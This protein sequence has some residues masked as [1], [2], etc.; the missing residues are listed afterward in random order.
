M[1]MGDDAMGFWGGFLLL[2]MFAF[3]ITFVVF[4]LS[5][6]HGIFLEL[7]YLVFCFLVEAFK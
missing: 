5:I 2:N 3:P 6:W 7:G 4:S 1:E